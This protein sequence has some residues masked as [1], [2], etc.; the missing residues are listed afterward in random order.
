MTQ[1]LN[2]IDEL[3][4][5]F[6]YSQELRHGLL[7][8][9]GGNML[10]HPQNRAPGEVQCALDQLSKFDIN[11]EFEVLLGPLRDLY[12]QKHLEEFIWRIDADIE[13]RKI[14]FPTSV[15]DADAIVVS[16]F[17]FKNYRLL[18]ESSQKVRKLFDV[19]RY[20]HS[21]FE[22]IGRE[23]TSHQYDLSQSFKSGMCFFNLKAQV[24]AECA[25]QIINLISERLPPTLGIAHMK[26]KST[27]VL[28]E[29]CSDIQMAIICF[30][31]K[32][33]RQFSETLWAYQSYVFYN[34]G[35]EIRG[36][37]DMSETDFLRHC[38][39][40]ALLFYNNNAP[41]LLY[42]AN[43]QIHWNTVPILEGEFDE[44]KAIKKA[45][46]NGWSYP[47]ENSRSSDINLKCVTIF[48]FFCSVCE[49]VLLN[50]GKTLKH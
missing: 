18:N 24:D 2:D 28:F 39:S 1:K 3:L 8:F 47:V 33:D 27:E 23:L 26:A 30:V 37:S 45:I 13:P 25:L 42:I 17:N 9:I 21:L 48:A 32:L 46:Q 15:P 36:V 19:E 50:S 16:E 14:V 44:G 11:E 35:K 22:G 34:D 7:F 20:L 38:R 29:G 6:G 4:E 49:T 40:R 12:I 43:K 5:R 31:S 10:F 41:A